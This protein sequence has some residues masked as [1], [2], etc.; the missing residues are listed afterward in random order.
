MKITVACESNKYYS[1]IKNAGFDGIDFSFATYEHRNR[2]IGDG[3]KDEI[4]ADYSV[5]SK[6]GLSVTQTHL[7]YYP[8]HIPPIGDGTYEAFEEYMLPIFI[9][10]IELTAMMNC[11]CAVAHLYFEK[12]REKSRTGNASL[13]GKL[14]PTLEKCGVVLAVE[15]IYGPEYS[16]AHL[17]TS[18]DLSYYS[19]YFGS[20]HVKVCLDTGHAI[21]RGQRPVEM[22]K[23]LGSRLAAVHLHTT[24]P[25]IDLHSIPYCTSYG[26]CVDWNELYAELCS[27]GFC[28][29]FNLEVR[30]PVEI[31]HKGTQAY[32]NLAYEIARGIIDENSDDT[33]MK[34]A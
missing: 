2:I 6:Q 33:D 29:T 30:P 1:A 24:V 19:D 31:G 28:G 18:A 5:I 4:A 12:D 25:G 3:Y 16:D 34:G 15:N 8:G 22:I 27:A 32:Y 26:E 11:K 14:L 7:T 20:D 13:I 21:I 9:R 10:E 23:Q 17:S